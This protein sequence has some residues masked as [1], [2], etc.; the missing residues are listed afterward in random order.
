MEKRERTGERKELSRHSNVATSRRSLAA[1]IPAGRTALPA[2]HSGGG[3]AEEG[4][5][6]WGRRW[7]SV[8]SESPVWG[9]RHRERDLVSGAY[10]IVCYQFE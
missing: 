8:S 4:G 7:V 3:A 6:R 10:D 9:G 5:R 1:T 2:A